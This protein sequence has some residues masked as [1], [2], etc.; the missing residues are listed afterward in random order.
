MFEM[1]LKSLKSRK[2]ATELLQNKLKN[3][4]VTQFLLKN[5]K[6][7]KSGGYK[8][9]FNLDVLSRDYPHIIAELS[10]D[11]PFEKDALFL[12]GSESNYIHPER[13]LPL[14]KEL[15]PYSELVTLEGAGHWLHADRPEEL[16]GILH[17]F[18]EQV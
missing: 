4:V 11:E 5:L 17:D 6:H 1:D 16:M 13:D 12:R 10:S 9:K 15:F 8:W 3:A 7:V 2:E 14:I 18:F